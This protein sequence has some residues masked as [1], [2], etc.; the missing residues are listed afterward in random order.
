MK[1]YKWLILGLFFSLSMA[2]GAVSLPS[3]SY[4]L[5]NKLYEP[6]QDNVSMSYGT[7]F[8][9]INT[10]IMAKNTTWAD[11]CYEEHGEGR[12]C[13]ECCGAYQEEY[14][15]DADQAYYDGLYSECLKACGYE[16][17]LGGAPLDIPAWFILPLCGL[18]GI[19]QRIRNKKLA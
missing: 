7:V 6:N 14:V 5:Y 10:R 19:V 15:D 8:K 17:P 4:L 18:Y 9:G 13:K 11:A 1:N 2:V 3:E 16:P 12:D